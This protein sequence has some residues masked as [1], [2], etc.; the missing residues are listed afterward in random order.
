MLIVKKNWYS[1]YW[2]SGYVTPSD[3]TDSYFYIRHYFSNR[4]AVNSLPASV[5]LLSL[6]DLPPG[7]SISDLQKQKE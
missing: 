7:M 4:H 5:K 6:Y 2:M 3:Y 1:L